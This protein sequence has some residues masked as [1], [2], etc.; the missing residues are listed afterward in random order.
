MKELEHVVTP[1]L[2]EAA[3]CLERDRLAGYQEK[4]IPLMLADI[5]EL[6]G[7]DAEESSDDRHGTY[8]S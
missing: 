6:T 7:Q 5:G 4:L 2:Q 8:G 1:Q 3:R